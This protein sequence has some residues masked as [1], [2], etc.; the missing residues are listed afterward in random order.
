MK[1]AFRQLSARE[2]RRLEAKERRSPSKPKRSKGS[3]PLIIGSALVFGPLEAILDQLEHDGTLTCSVR[4]RPMFRDL[5]DGN[6]YDTAAALAGVIDHLEMYEIR[7]KVTLPVEGLRQFH[8][9]VDHGMNIPGSLLDQLRRDLPALQRVMA[10]SNP[11][12]IVDLY[13]QVQI[14]IEMEAIHGES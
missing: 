5:T 14:K 7:H 1:P 12:D 2:L 10:L 4:G 11:D 13:R 9:F 3:T 8:R 6:W